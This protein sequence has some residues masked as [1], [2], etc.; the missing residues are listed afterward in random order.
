MKTENRFMITIDT[1]DSITDD[2]ELNEMAQNI[3][4]AIINEANTKGI[5]PRKVRNFYK[6]CKGKT[7]V[8]RKGN[9]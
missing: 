8:R 6:H 7:L 4:N 1:Q 3:A 9:N 5:V 2:N